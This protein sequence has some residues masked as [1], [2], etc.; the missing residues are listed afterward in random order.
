MTEQDLND[1]AIGAVLQKM[2]AKTVA[3]GVNGN[4]FAQ[5]CRPRRFPARI[6]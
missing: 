3:Q 2:G 6:L 4:P 1:A 5:A